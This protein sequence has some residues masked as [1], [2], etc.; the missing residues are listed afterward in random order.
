MDTVQEFQRQ[1]QH[2]LKQLIEQQIADNFVNDCNIKGL[3][4]RYNNEP[5]P[6]NPN[7]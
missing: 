7:I 1:V 3:T 4:S 2:A 6:G 5:I